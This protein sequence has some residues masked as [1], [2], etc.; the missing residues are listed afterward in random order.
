[1][2]TEQPGRPY[3]RT[4]HLILVATLCIPAG[5]QGEAQLRA[6][7]AYTNLFDGD[8]HL[9]IGPD[10]GVDIGGGGCVV[11]GP[12]CSVPNWT[13]LFAAYAGVVTDDTP[14]SAYLHTGVERKLDA[15]LSLGVLGFW[16]VH[17]AQVGAAARLDAKDVA[18]LKLGYGWGDRDGAM[19]AVE[20]AFAFI[21]DLFR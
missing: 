10:I 7:V 5:V 14:L 9:L 3:L 11:G 16:F 8:L 21:R 17:P 18:A 20:I 13:F 12:P 4:V 6:Q 19:L 15:D 1:M 2:T